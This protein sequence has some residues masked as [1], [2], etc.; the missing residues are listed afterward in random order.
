MNIMTTTMTTTTQ[1]LTFE[2]YLDYSDGTDTRYELIHGELSP[3]SLGLLIC[4][5]LKAFQIEI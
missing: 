1:K 4:K 5:S 2:E 3:M